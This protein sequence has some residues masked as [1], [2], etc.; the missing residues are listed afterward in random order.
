MTNEDYP[1]RKAPMCRRCQDAP[2]FGDYD[3]CEECLNN[4]WN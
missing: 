3:V 2:C 4:G 1:R